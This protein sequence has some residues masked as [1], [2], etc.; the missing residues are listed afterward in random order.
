MH[1]VDL[2]AALHEQVVDRAVELVGLHA[3][4]DRERALRVE[5]DEEHPAAV[6][7][8]R[9]A[10]VDGGRGLA[11]AALLVRHRDD[12]GRAVLVE[13]SRFGNL[14][15]VSPHGAGLA[16][17]LLLVERPQVAGGEGARRRSVH[18]GAPVCRGRPAR[19]VR[20]SRSA[21]RRP[22]TRPAV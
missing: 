5:V 1:V 9:R 20:Q 7:G 3:E 13:R 14:Q 2:D 19:A 10:E 8:E 11:D 18:A 22:A 4:A 6:L 15:A 16:G 17:P 12:P 21:P